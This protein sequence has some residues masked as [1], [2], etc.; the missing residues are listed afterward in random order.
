MAGNQETGIIIQARYSSTRL[1]GKLFLPFYED[2]KMIEVFLSELIAQVKNHLPIVLATTT[3]KKDDVF[4]PV[5]KD[6]NIHCFRGS[7]EDVLERTCEAAGFYGFRTVVR[8]CADNP[9]Y[10]MERTLQLIDVHKSNGADY[11]SY[12]LSTKLPSIKSH[13]GLWGEVVQVDAL[14][15]ARKMT[16]EKLY[17]EHVT[18]FLYTHPQQFKIQL[19]DAP[20]FLYYRNDLRFTVDRLEDFNMM[21]EIYAQLKAVNRPIEMHHLVGLVDRHPEYLLQMKNQIERNK[22]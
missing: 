10:D 1:P 18:N 3:N 14:Q 11:T 15:K 9:V 8:V 17:H 22:K 13:L 16:R 19:L 12:R 2:K 6:F 20:E 7:E 5:A 4:E 21:K